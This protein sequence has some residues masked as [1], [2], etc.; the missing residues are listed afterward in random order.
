MKEPLKIEKSNKRITNEINSYETD[1]VSPK[2]Q[3]TAVKS[4]S[5]GSS[6]R[7]GIKDINSATSKTQ[8]KS[9]GHHKKSLS[10]QETTCSSALSRR[11]EFPLDS[12]TASD[13]FGGH[14][15]PYEKEE[16][17]KYEEIYFVGDR[18]HKLLAR[19]EQEF[20]DEK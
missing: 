9:M 4:S 11:G 14:L 12:K 16:I 18:Y 5:R 6:G 1:A 10:M 15:S 8:F 13:L 2:F 7:D 19:D 20:D 17:F 3:D